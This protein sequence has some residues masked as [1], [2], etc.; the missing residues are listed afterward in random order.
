MPQR[1]LADLL[2]FGELQHGGTARVEVEHDKLVVH[3][4]AA[5]DAAH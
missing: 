5:D 3:G 4:E 2:L 1:P